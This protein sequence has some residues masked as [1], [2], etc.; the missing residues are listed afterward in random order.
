LAFILSKR[1]ILCRGHRAKIATHHHDF[2]ISQ[3]KMDRA[4]CGISLLIQFHRQ[5]DNLLRAR[6]TVYQVA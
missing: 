6:T 3:Y 5:F 2:V 1:R 4:A